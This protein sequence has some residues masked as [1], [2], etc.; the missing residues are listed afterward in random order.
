MKSN[1]K[2]LIA[3]AVAL[4]ILCG[5][6][7]VLMVTGD[8]QENTPEETTTATT[9]PLSKLLYDKDPASIEN[10]HIKNETGEY[11]LK[12]YAD[13]AWFIPDF[14]GHNHDTAAVSKTL[15]AAA[16]VTSE[17]VA[18]ESAADLSVYGLDVPKAEVTI[19]FADSGNTVK[20]LFI[21][22]E[23]PTGDYSYAMFEGETTVH[24]LDT[25]A[26]DCFFNDKFS[27]I[28]RTVY[29]AKQPV[30]EEDTTDYSKINMISISRKDIDYDIV[31][32]YDVRQDSEDMISG[33]SASHIMTSPV[34]L[35]L[36]PDTSYNTINNVLGLT[37]SKVAVVSPSE[38]TLAMFGLADPFAEVNFDIVGGDFRFLIGNPYTDENGNQTGYYCMADGIDVIYIFDNE[39]IPWA[40]VKPLDITMTMMTTTYIYNI[41]SLSVETADKRTEFTLSG[42]SDDLA[43][44]CNG[45]DIDAEGFKSFYQ[46]I[47]RAPAEELYLESTSVAADAKI[48]IEHTSGTDTI[49]FIPSEDRK[50]IVRINGV[51]SFKLR[52]AYTDRLTEN[53]DKLLSGEEIIV[54]W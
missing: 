17:K 38:E 2:L 1:I 48:I 49:E 20:K 34:R 50:S 8:S 51:E 47:L 52:T 19:T 31:L 4:V 39:T 12:K 41:S 45:Q 32:E 24:A 16:T 42:G 54:T 13:D 18:A 40:T 7:V 26:I 25:A 27:Y 30:N 5:A 9:A 10:I 6:V 37:A 29:T 21:G 14:V 15:S 3:V 28:A 43:V 35:D 23:A 11:D 46:F 33:N 44:T 22:A 53:L 36:N